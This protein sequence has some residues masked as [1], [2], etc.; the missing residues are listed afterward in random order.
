MMVTS[1]HLEDAEEGSLCVHVFVCSCAFGFRAVSCLSPAGSRATVSRAAVTQ[2]F[3][4]YSPPLQP[5]SSLPPSLSPS[6]VALPFFSV[7]PLNRLLFSNSLSSSLLPPLHALSFLF[8]YDQCSLNIYTDNY[9]FKCR[10]PKDF[11][12]L[13][14]S[15]YSHA[16]AR[17]DFS[18]LCLLF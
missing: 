9:Y 6:L 1:S 7:V 16:H 14:V 11:Q 17:A 12:K 10:L 18:S 15:A 2:G 4:S 3:C 5:S 13:V 8:L